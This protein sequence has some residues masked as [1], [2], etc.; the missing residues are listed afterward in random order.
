[1]WNYIHLQNIPFAVPLLELQMILIFTLTQVSHYVLK[2]YGVPKFT[3]QLLVGIILGPS[4]LGRFRI[5]SNVLFSIDGQETIG[6][7]SVFSYVLFSYVSAVKMDL[8]MIKRTGKN[9]LF[10]GVVCTLSPLLIGLSIQA[11]LGRLWSLSK[12]E[13]ESLPSMTTI[14]SASPFP[15]LVC[16][17]E[18]LNILNSQLGRLALSAAMVSDALNLFSILVA[19]NTRTKLEQGSITAAIDV[20]AIIAYLIVLV[21]VIRPAMFWVIRQTPK[22]RPVKDIYIHAIMLMVLGSGLLSHFFGQTFFFGP[23]LFGLAVPD[24]PPLGSAIVNKFNCIISD[25]FLPLFVAICGMKTNLSLIKFD[26]SFMKINGILIASTFVAKMVACLVP[27]LYSKMPLNDAL[28]LSL[29]LSC[30]GVFQLFAYTYLIDNKI[31][32]DQ[33]FALLCVFIL[34]TAIF[35]PLLVKFLYHPSRQYAGYQKKDIMHCASNAELRILTC[36]Y[37]QDNVVAITKLLEISC[38]SRERPLAI[39]VLHLIELIGR[40][41]PIFISHQMQIKTMSNSSYSENIIHSFDHFEQDNEGA[42]SVDFFTAISPLKSMHDDICILGLDKLTSLIVL[43]FHRKWSIDGSVELEDNTMRTLNC[44]VLELAPCSV[45]ILIDRGH[46]GSSMVSS[47]SSYSVAMIFFG[48]D[49]DREALSFAKRM[50]NHSKIALTVIHFVATYNEGNTY[51]DEML[52]SEVL[53]DAKLNN[54]GDEYVIYLEVTVKDGP[55]TALMVRCMV[56]EYDL[57]IVGRRYNVE[58]LQTSGLAEW[59][60][61]QELG[62]IGDLL[63]SSDLNSR[64]SVF[65]VQQQQ[66]R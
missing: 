4:F 19:I 45:G 36:I 30:K 35:M 29:L 64:T 55:Q 32:T 52:D 1:M 31:I 59:S 42:V 41:S 15:V 48:G 51:W 24:G 25:V 34:F 33:A 37:R 12:E 9:A 50:A 43:P 6:L 3:T 38:P 62:V 28:A 13:A 17:L 26:N 53:K 20:G 57:I 18:D 8:G 40:A 66:N 16:L 10:V 54:I 14:H 58:S 56:N 65:V 44:S 63:A 2:R 21:Y 47:E 60:E 39:Y 61:F 27:P 49:D 11:V 22:G 5:V 46:L 7:L 23:F